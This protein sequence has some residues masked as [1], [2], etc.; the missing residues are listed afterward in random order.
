M[1]KHDVLSLPLARFRGLAHLSRKG[2]I[3][4]PFPGATVALGA[5]AEQTIPRKRRYLRIPRSQG[6]CRYPAGKVQLERARESEAKR[7]PDHP[8]C[9]VRSFAPV[10]PHSSQHSLLRKGWLALPWWEFGGTKRPRWP[11]RQ[12]CADHSDRQQRRYVK[13]WPDALP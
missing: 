4:T 13:R 11:S 8:F 12:G 2:P 7:E 9:P 5:A 3:S 6:G 1:T 10:R